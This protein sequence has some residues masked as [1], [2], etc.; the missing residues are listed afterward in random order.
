MLVA[1]KQKIFLT[2]N[3]ITEQGMGY[4]VWGVGCSER[5]NKGIKPLFLN[6]ERKKDV[7]RDT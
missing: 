7:F 5:G 6:I 3:I 2:A 1:Q 4:G